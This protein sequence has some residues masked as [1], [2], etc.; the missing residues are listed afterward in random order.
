MKG[1]LFDFK[2]WDFRSARRLSDGLFCRERRDRE[3]Q[4]RRFAESTPPKSAKLRSRRTLESETA[5]ATAVTEARAGKDAAAET[6]EPG[7]G[8][9]GHRCRSRTPKGG[10]CT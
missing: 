1:E 3:G 5:I 8:Q 2:D 6:A 10:T 7:R 9:S 4:H